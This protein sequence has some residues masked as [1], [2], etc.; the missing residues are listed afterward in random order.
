MQI[1]WSARSKQTLATIRLHIRTHFTAKEELEFVKQVIQPIQSIDA[2]PQGF[3]ECKKPK[4]ARKAV[5]RPHST[6]FYRI[7]SKKRIELLFF[8]DNRNNPKKIK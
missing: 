1:I 2:F 5:I 3:P 7:K 4:H 6:L 8:G